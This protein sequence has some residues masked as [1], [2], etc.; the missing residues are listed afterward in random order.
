MDGDDV[1]DKHVSSPR[2]RHGK[3]GH[4]CQRRRQHRACP[5]SPHPPEEGEDEQEDRDALV[6]EGAS[7]G[8]RDN[9]NSANN[10]SDRR[11]PKSLKSSRVMP[12][13]IG[14]HAAGRGAQT[15]RVPAAVAHARRLLPARAQPHV[16][17]RGALD[18]HDDAEGAAERGERLPSPHGVC[19]SCQVV[20]GRPDTDP[21]AAAALPDARLPLGDRGDAQQRP[22]GRVV[23][24]ADPL[25]ADVLAPLLRRGDARQ[26]RGDG[27][28]QQ[29][30]LRLGLVRARP[31]AV[32]VVPA[33]EQRQRARE[34]V[35]ADV[36]H[37]V[38]HGH[39]RAVLAAHAAR[40]HG[41]PVRELVA[42]RHAA[43]AVPAAAADADPDGL[44]RQPGRVHGRGA[45]RRAGAHEGLVSGVL[46]A[47]A[48]CCQSQRGAQLD[49]ATLGDP[50]YAIF[51]SSQ[52]VVLGRQLNATE[53]ISIT[54]QTARMAWAL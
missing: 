2:Q 40:R 14:P 33:R 17:G 22:A 42:A 35:P 30:E 47:R 37:D 6:V 54:S 38:V 52:I 50:K 26:L 39:V 19:T 7:R 29:P 12:S 4:R 25:A 49:Y 36:H 48:W 1:D 45:Q 3:V 24:P 13:P 34:L 32:L 16:R 9:A 23:P 18:A 43:T 46:S 44:R 53:V 20:H 21:R 5:H 11:S 10:A 41:P 27:H 8:A 28:D 51:G 31:G 15:R